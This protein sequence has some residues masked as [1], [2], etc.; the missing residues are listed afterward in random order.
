MRGREVAPAGLVVEARTSAA[1]ASPL[2]VG[3]GGGATVD[4][5][6]LRT[7]APAPAMPAS[8][9]PKRR[10]G[11]E[12]QRGGA[13][14]RPASAPVLPSARRRA[15]RSENFLLTQARQY[16]Y[17][18]STRSPGPRRQAP[19]LGV[20]GKPARSPQVI[21]AQP[22]ISFLERSAPKGAHA[23]KG[24]GPRR[25]HSLIDLAGNGVSPQKAKPMRKYKRPTLSIT[26]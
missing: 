24:Q 23:D 15:D 16:Q 22:Y 25:A 4:P 11:G 8:A 14:F 3:R 17:L 10:G 9:S 19:E 12:T 26:Y 18:D 6:G 1:P 21:R 5:R 13:L 2:V 20:L 7:W